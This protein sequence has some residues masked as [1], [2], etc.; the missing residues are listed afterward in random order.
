M[1]IGNVWLGSLVLQGINNT[2]NLATG[3]FSMTT[4][5]LSV[6]STFDWATVRIADTTEVIYIS[7]TP[8]AG[9]AYSTIVWKAETSGYSSF[10]WQPDRPMLLAPGDH[11]TV[12]VTNANLSGTVYGN[13]LTLY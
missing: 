8:A 7:M 13:M 6:A 9:S 2:Q 11:I 4:P 1:T 12:R 5:I 10:F 3:S